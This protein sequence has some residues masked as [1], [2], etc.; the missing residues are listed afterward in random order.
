MTTTEATTNTDPVDIGTLQARAAELR[1]A[2]GEALTAMDDN[3]VRKLS[4]ELA[5]VNKSILDLEATAQL[6]DR[7]DFMEA[8]HD[9]LNAYEV[10]GLTL[11]VRFSQADDGKVSTNVVF[12]ATDDVLDAIKGT[13]ANITRPSSVKSWTYGRDDQGQQSFDFG[14][15]PRKST[16]TNGT[17]TMGWSKDGQDISLGDAF[18]AC[19]TAKEK[20]EYQ[21]LDTGS[22]QHA[23][24]S[25]VVTAAGYTKK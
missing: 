8:M 1:T 13:I 15:G 21:T 12:T 11:T 3:K 22:K 9:A 23:F 19:A 16:G 10:D 24:K 14:K 17:R 5:A 18:D 20:S 4:N 6:G 7:N 2:M 25:K